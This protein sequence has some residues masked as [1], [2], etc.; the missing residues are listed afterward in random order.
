MSGL[1]IVG[2]AEQQMHITLDMQ[3]LSQ[4]SLSIPRIITLLQNENINVS[5]GSKD[6]D[7]RVYR[8]RTVNKFNSIEE[9]ENLIVYS[10]RQ[11]K[12]YLRGCPR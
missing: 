6:V 3:K 5:A 1:Q 7:R 9:M 10:N 12:I 8:I 2:G 11:S 4:Y